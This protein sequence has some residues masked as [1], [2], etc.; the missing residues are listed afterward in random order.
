MKWP[1]ILFLGAALWLGAVGEDR[2]STGGPYDLSWF[3]VDGGNGVSG[4][5]IYIARAVIGQPDAGPTLGAVPYQARGGFLASEEQG[6]PSLGGVTDN[7][8]G[9]LHLRWSNRAAACAQFLGFSWDIY[10]EGWVEL[11]PV[12]SLWYPYLRTVPEGNMRVDYS[13]GYHVWMSNQYYDGDWHA[14]VNPWT[15]ILYG[16]TPHKPINVL[17]HD[18]GGR[19]ARLDWKPDIY[20]AWHYQ[21]FV[22][23]VDE[24]RWVNTVG[25]SGDSPWHFVFFLS[26][27]FM[28]GSALFT[29][30]SA[31]AYWF[32]IRGAGWLAPYPTGEFATAYVEVTE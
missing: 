5:G 29:V 8:N 15:G 9:S 1:R 11:S 12:G 13:G 6:P 24:A 2:A 23:S 20:G 18:T 19:Q 28:N 25:P 10:Q 7:V 14:C 4:G 31:G 22:Y 17:A 30:P 21:I 26:G 3:S 27:D 16:G 32:W